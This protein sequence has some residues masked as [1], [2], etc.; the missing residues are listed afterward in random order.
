MI[1]VRLISRENTTVAM[2]V[3]DRRAPGDV[4]RPGRL[5]DR[6]PGRDD[7]HLTG[8]QAVGELVEVGE[9]GR[10]TDHLAADAGGDLDLVDRRL[11]DVAEDVVVL[12]AAL[13]G[14]LVHLGLGRV[15]DVVDVAAALGVAQLDDPRA[16]LDEPAQ[17]RPLGDDLRVVAGVGRRR[18][19]RDEL[20]QVGL[21]TDPG[22]VAALGQLVGDGDRVGR[23]AAPVEVEDRVVDRLVR[24]PVEV[25]AAQHLDGVGDGVLGQQHAAEDRPL[26][27]DILWRKPVVGAVA[28]SGVAAHVKLGDRH[29]AVLSKPSV[30]SS[31]AQH[32]RRV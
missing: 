4:E 24:R 3:L 21:A 1:S 2:L 26:G 25:G 23:L 9:T 30:A 7:D 22:Q 19:R 31:V 16:G 20:V 13:V 27:V 6:R 17:H 29:A 14:D 28:G 32:I 10:H 5:A 11:E 18:H 12:A 15:D 8:V